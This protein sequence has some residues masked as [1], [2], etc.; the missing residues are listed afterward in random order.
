MSRHR[1]F[2]DASYLSLRL[3]ANVIINGAL[4]FLLATKVALCGLHRDMPEQ[5]LDLF[6]LSTCNVTEPG[7]CP[8]LMPHAAC[9][10][11]AEFRTMPNVLSGS[12]PAGRSAVSDSA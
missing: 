6:E 1:E 7:A 5:K 9:R 12:A 3:D 8:P 4:D 2:D 10:R 11:Y